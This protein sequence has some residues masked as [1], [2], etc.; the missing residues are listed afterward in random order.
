MAVFTIPERENGKYHWVILRGMR[1]VEKIAKNG[2][3]YYSDPFYDFQLLDSKVVK[4]RDKNA[5]VRGSTLERCR[6]VT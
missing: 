4:E 2:K 5:S 3:P 6:A 1:V